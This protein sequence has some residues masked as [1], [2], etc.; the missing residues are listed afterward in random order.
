M[1]PDFPDFFY[2]L[3]VGGGAGSGIFVYSPAPGA[4]NLI[5]S[6]TAAAGTDPFGNAYKAGI[7]SYQLGTG[8]FAQLLAGAFVVGKTGSGFASNPDAGTDG[9]GQQLILNSASNGVNNGTEIALGLTKVTIQKQAGAPAVPLLDVVGFL[10]ATGVNIT[11]I[12]AG[13]FTVTETGGAPAQPP[14]EFEGLTAGDRC[15]GIRVTGDANHRLRVDD[16]GVF[17]WGS[18]AGGGD[19]NLYRG[20][21]NQLKTDDAFNCISGTN[22]NPTVI[23]TDSW[24][25]LGAL[26]AHY[27]VTRGRYRLT[28]DNELELDIEVIGDGLQAT[29]VTFANTLVA[30]YVP[31]TSHQFLPMGTNRAVTA[32]DVWPR[33][34]VTAAGAVTVNAPAV[35]NTFSTCVRVPLD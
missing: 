19:T 30:P 21:A 10:A 35:S 3:V 31:A 32:G 6:I 18:G 11:G 2:V 4:G 15:I 25:S 26:G 29:S 27:T 12:G 34:T 24:Q 7:T 8:I 5:A 9:G 23:T 13:I 28:P 17:L 14:T 16:T 20:A 22:S 33:V 1:Q